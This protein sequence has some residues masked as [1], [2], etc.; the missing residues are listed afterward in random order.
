MCSAVSSGASGSVATFFLEEGVACRSALVGAI[1]K[2]GRERQTLSVETF[3]LVSFPLV[4]VDSF[5]GVINHSGSFP[6]N[7]IFFFEVRVQETD[8]G[9]SW[10]KENLRGSQQ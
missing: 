3:N 7:Y 4:Q 9:L 6:I 2:C 1:S 5:D 10:G 8:G